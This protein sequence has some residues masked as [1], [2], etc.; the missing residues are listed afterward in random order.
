MFDN[1]LLLATTIRE[2][3]IIRRDNF[4]PVSGTALTKS[5]EYIC[6]LDNLNNENFFAF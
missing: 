1:D 3:L 4:E 5:N 6:L 2:R